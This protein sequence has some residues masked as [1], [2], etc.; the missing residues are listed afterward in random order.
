MF[1]STAGDVYPITIM[2]SAASPAEG[3][4]AGF[5]RCLS[6]IVLSEEDKSHCRTLSPVSA[7]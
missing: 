3:D 4:A 2:H 6:L 1:D 7:F 5:K